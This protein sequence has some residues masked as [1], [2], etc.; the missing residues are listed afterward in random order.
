[1]R[2]MLISMVIYSTKKNRDLTKINI[3]IFNLERHSND[4]KPI[5]IFTLPHRPM[6]PTPEEKS[7]NINEINSTTDHIY[8]TAQD[9]PQSLIK[10]TKETSLEDRVKQKPIFIKYMFV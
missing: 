2:Q 9:I 10:Q 5:S 1:M 3:I 6:P 8:L 4:D 7:V